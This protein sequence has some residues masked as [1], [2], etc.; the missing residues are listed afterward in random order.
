MDYE[1]LAGELMQKMFL[2]GNARPNMDIAESMRGE[3]I[4]LHFIERRDCP[5]KPSEISR[6]VQ[7][8]TARV[9]ATLNSLEKKGLVTREIDENDRRRILVK[10]TPAGRKMVE[11]KHR[12]VVRM[13]STMLSMLGEEDA[14]EFVRIT[15]RLA[16]LASLMVE[17]K[18]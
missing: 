12:N 2:V 10:L 11:E 18:Q 3:M 6:A 13:V 17:K 4:V 15:G 7:R 9:A 5:V 14:R 8:T 16:D 1:K